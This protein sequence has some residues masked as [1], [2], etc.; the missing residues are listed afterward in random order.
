MVPD[1]KDLNLLAGKFN[2]QLS[3]QV[4]SSPS[5]CHPARMVVPFPS[6]QT[7]ESGELTMP[8]IEKEDRR[9]QESLRIRLS[10]SCRRTAKSRTAQFAGQFRTARRQRR[11]ATAVCERTRSLEIPRHY[12]PVVTPDEEMRA[13]HRQRGETH[14]IQT[15]DR[16]RKQPCNV[17]TKT[18][19]QRSIRNSTCPTADSFSSTTSPLTAES[20]SLAR[21]KSAQGTENPQR[22]RVPLDDPSNFQK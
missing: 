2:W 12:P 11:A 15:P 14:E 19:F 6:T 9:E 10:A 16:W 22:G 18:T 20:K 17:T 1:T 21:R 7:H 3:C 4:R 13:D 8:L 5:V